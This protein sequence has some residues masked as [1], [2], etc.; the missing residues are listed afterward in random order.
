MESICLHV[1]GTGEIPVWK[2]EEMQKQDKR[3]DDSGYLR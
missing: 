3:E 2:V 1:D